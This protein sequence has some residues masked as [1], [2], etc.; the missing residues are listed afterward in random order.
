VK[1]YALFERVSRGDASQADWDDFGDA[2][3]EERELI[4]KLDELRTRP[5]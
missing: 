5:S 1:V 3:R 2:S 4:R